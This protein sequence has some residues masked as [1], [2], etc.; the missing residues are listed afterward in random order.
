MQIYFA[1]EG[2][3]DAAVAQRLLM[4]AGLEIARSPGLEHGFLGWHAPPA[5]M[6]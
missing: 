3:G 1:T 4:H 2:D 6:C 5:R